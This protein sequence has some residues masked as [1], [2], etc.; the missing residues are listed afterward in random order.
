MT[1]S[2]LRASPTLP[3]YKERVAVS[4]VNLC[5][6]GDCLFSV[7]VTCKPGFTRAG[8][9]VRWHQV[10]STPQQQGSKNHFSSHYSCCRCITEDLRLLLLEHFGKM[11]REHTS[12]WLMM[13]IM[14]TNKLSKITQTNTK[15]LIYQ[16]TLQTSI[17]LFLLSK[18][19][20]SSVTLVPVWFTAKTVSTCS[21]LLFFSALR[22]NWFILFCVTSIHLKIHLYN[23]K[24]CKEA[25]S[26]IK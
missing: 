5:N 15:F 21:D 26:C 8:A 9:G 4:H 13:D 3:H 1:S 14:K 11:L 7:R 17:N 25:Y 10:S 6:S 2:G 20:R 23:I 24:N 22:N 18:N 12:F 16:G 19:P